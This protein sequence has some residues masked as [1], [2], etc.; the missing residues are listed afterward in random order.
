MLLECIISIIVIWVTDNFAHLWR[1]HTFYIDNFKDSVKDVADFLF[2]GPLV[3]LILPSVLN[4]CQAS[5]ELDEFWPVQVS[6][7]IIWV[8]TLLYHGHLAHVEGLYHAFFSAL[9]NYTRAKY[10]SDLVYTSVIIIYELNTVLLCVEWRFCYEVKEL[11]NPTNIN[12]EQITHIK[13]P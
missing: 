4:L 11:P 13:S 12:L 3:F 10:S 7:L 1:I 6:I 9:R 8:V 5:H 2:E